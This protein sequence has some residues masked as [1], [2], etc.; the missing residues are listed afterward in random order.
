MFK[1]ILCFLA[2]MFAATG[3]SLSSDT[4]SQKAGFD[5][6]RAGL[7]SEPPDE[8]ERALLLR[9]KPVLHVADGEEGPIAFYADYIGS[10]DLFDGAGNF[11]ASDPDAAALN[12]LRDDPGAVFVHRPRPALGRPSVLG[13]FSRS[14]LTLSSGEAREFSF[15][16]YHFVFRHSGL[17]AGIPTAYRVLAD[18]VADSRDW[19]QLDHYTAA[20]VVL[21]GG[22]PFAVILQCHNYMRTYFMED[23][24]AFADGRVKIDA[25][26]SSNELYPHQDGEARRRAAGFMS[27]KTVDYLTGQGSASSLTSA[28]DI[29]AGGREVSYDLEFLPPNDA[30]YSFE[31]RLGEPRSLP[32]RDGPPGSIYR[33]HP[34]NWPLEKALYVFYWLS[35]DPEYAALVKQG[36][37][38]EESSRRM[39]ER[40]SARFLALGI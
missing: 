10:G 8:M 38:S 5:E 36:R 9:H 33:A 32:G 11:V 18:I 40:F 26:I 12:A 6:I 35:D 28:D 3:I 16:S 27:A 25:A 2:C 24:P 21:A 13:G 22:Q 23:E 7:G 34:Q 37:D 20:F 17:P 1:K 31:G 15:L 30:F 29:T 14:T 19:H 39:L 4:F